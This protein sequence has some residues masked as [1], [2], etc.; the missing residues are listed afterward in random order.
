MD[1]NQNKNI[2]ELEKIVRA[3]H[4][5]GIDRKQLGFKRN[6]HIGKDD[7]Q[8]NPFP[9]K[10]ALRYRKTGQGGRRGGGGGGEGGGGDCIFQIAE[11]RYIGE[12][13]VIVKC[14]A[15]FH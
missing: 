14:G 10:A 4:D 5:N 6:H 12:S 9:R 15:G 13:H 1:G 7:K 8:R 2:E 11:H 3:M